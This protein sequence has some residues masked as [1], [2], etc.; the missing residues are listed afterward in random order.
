MSTYTTGLPLYR[1]PRMASQFFLGSY[2]EEWPA[3]P[4]A[5]VQTTFSELAHGMELAL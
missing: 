1:K 5:V 4:S 2:T 3:D